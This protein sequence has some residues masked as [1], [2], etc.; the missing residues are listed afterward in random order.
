MITAVLYARV[1]SEKQAQE[2]TIVSQIAALENRIMTDGYKL[3]EFKFI[4]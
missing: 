2:N 1:S 4:E 3:D